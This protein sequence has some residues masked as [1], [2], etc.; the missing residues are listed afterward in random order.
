MTTLPP[1][2]P[3]TEEELDK[4][5][6]RQRMTCIQM[7]EE[8]W[9]KGKH[10][11][12][13]LDINVWEMLT[14]QMVTSIDHPY[15]VLFNF[16]REIIRATAHIAA[17]YKPNYAF[18]AEHG[19]EG[20]KALEDTILEVNVLAPE[21][22]VILDGKF[23]DI[24]NTNEAYAR[25]VFHKLH[26]DAVTVIPYVGGEALQ[27]FLA[28]KNKGVFVLCRTSNKGAGEFQDLG[29]TNRKVGYLYEYVAHRVAEEWNKEGNCGL[30]VGATYPEELREV[31][32]IAPDLP[33]LIPGIGAQGGDLE[34]SAKA[35]QHRFVI[36][37]SRK[38]IFAPSPRLEAE[39]THDAITKA[40]K[41]G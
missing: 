15:K 12:V 33:I 20:L 25:L 41:G 2:P 28:D 30:V 9:K 36:N 38:I 34:A 19:P 37:S 13:G 22:P 10:L 23:G 24:R 27:P 6:I 18:Y 17:A 1:L 31:R 21:V 32:K 3:M 29:I 11:C 26:A 7:L 16:G 40:L 8:Q 14:R 4:I 35:A 39:K 5:T